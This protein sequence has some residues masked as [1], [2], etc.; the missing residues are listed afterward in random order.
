MTMLRLCPPVRRRTL[1]AIRRW[2]PDLSMAN[3][4]IRPPR[5]MKLVDLKY[6]TDVSFVDMMPTLW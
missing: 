3:A 1:S 2:R 5:N 6:V 4:M